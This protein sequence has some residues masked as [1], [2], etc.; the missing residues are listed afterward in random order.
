[1][2]KIFIPVL[3]L[4]FVLP[5]TS[6][7]QFAIES[8]LV[9]GAG[10]NQLNRTVPFH[11]GLGMGLSYNMLSSPVSIGWRVN[12]NFYS[13]YS[14][15]QLPYYR[16]DYV[17]EVAD[18]SNSHTISLNSFFVR[19]E[20]NR[21]GFVSPFA[22]LG[23]GWAAYKTRWS[24]S[25]PFEQSNDDCEGYVE[26]NKF[27]SEKTPVVTASAGVNLKL[28]NLGDKCSG[29]WIT[30]AVD[31]S[32]GK[33]VYHLN[34]KLN[35][36]QF[37]YDAGAPI[38]SNTSP[39]ATPAMQPRHGD[40]NHDHHNMTPNTVSTEIPDEEYYRQ[41]VFKSRHEFLQLRVGVTWFIGKC[42]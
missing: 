42:D 2:N 11:A 34:S 19:G 37:Y 35:H 40:G 16:E 10:M 4:L 3:P 23:G 25:D 31:Y 14:Q 24:A 28:H 7:A 32:R 20:V 21:H 17:H 1:M 26:S 27:M 33:E 22:E 9:M 13:T 12:G 38:V 39:T 36:A 30:L 15:D 29:I 6:T 5:F 18:I 41:P 8:H